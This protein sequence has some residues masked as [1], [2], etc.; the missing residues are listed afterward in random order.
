[1]THRGNKWSPF[2]DR[3]DAKSVNSVWR[4]LYLA[5]LCAVF[6]IY[7]VQAVRLETGDSVGVD[8]LDAF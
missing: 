8:S 7:L 1:M 2:A 5:A 6:C 3:I 4:T